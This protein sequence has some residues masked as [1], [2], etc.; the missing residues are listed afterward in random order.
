MSVPTGRPLHCSLLPKTRGSP[1]RIPAPEDR[2]D[3]TEGQS[4]FCHGNRLPR[5]H[6]DAV[7]SLSFS[8]SIVSF[9]Q[10]HGDHNGHR[11]QKNMEIS[12]VISC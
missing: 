6:S 9:A 2:C 8:S 1:D 4:W 10:T 12:S 7:P 3:N 5:R 11:L